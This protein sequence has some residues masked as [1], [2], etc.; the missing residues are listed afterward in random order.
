MTHLVERL[1]ELR[2]HLD[3]ALNDLEPI[4]RFA[5]IV[6]TKLLSQR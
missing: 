4:E 5:E 1:A 3:H 6:R 2:L